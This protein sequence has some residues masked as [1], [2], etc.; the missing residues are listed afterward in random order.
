MTGGAAVRRSSA[1]IWPEGHFLAHAAEDRSDR[2][3]STREKAE[4]RRQ[5]K[6]ER[7]REQVE[8]GSLVIRPMTDDERLRYP[9]PVAKPK[10]RP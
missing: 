3:K 7:V 10:R 4:E 1:F 2:M 9:P 5:E 8:S 6:L